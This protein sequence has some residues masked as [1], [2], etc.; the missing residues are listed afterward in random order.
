MLLFDGKYVFCLYF[1]SEIVNCV[2]PG[3][4]A[5]SSQTDNKSERD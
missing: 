4:S 3:Y 5:A 1:V 2:L